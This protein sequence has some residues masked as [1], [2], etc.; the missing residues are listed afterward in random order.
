MHNPTIFA[1]RLR[2]AREANGIK[3]KELAER[4]GVS[5]QTISAYEKSDVTGK[6]KNPTLENA[7]SIAKE[8][9]VSLDWLYGLE[10]QR[11]PSEKYETLGDIARAIVEISQQTHISIVQEFS[12]DVF[13]ETPI[14]GRPEIYFYEKNIR[15][16]LQEWKKMLDLRFDNTIDARLYQLWLDDKFRTMDGMKIEE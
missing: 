6:V 14:E 5:S 1:Q 16:F 4:I 9:G 13:L 11:T 15:K 10:D 3:Q 2:E 7:V 12:K 8:L